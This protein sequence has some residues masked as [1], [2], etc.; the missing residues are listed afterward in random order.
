MEMDDFDH[1]DDHGEIKSVVKVEKSNYSPM[2]IIEDPHTISVPGKPEQDNHYLEPEKEALNDYQIK[3]YEK[4]K[5][6]GYFELFKYSPTSL[7]FVIFGATIF[8][9]LAGVMQGLMP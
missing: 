8:S 2:H 1:I 3:E 7:K 5:V 9:M 6:I 4:G